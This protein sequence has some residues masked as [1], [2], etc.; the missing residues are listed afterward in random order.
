MS[1]RN[2]T[3]TTWFDHFPNEIL[4]LIFRYLSSN[5]IVYTFSCFNQRFNN[6]LFQNPCYLKLNLR[7]TN[8][9]KWE[10]VL[11]IIGSQIQSRDIDT[12]YLSSSLTYFSNLK[13]LIISPSYGLSN[14]EMKLILKSDQFKHL[15]SFK[16]KQSQFF[17]KESHNNY[18][19]N[20]DYIFNKVFSTENSLKTFQ[21]S[22]KIPSFTD[23]NKKK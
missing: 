1:L 12:F 21:Y 8:L 5:D 4:F 3:S 7:T 16:L 14:K 13:S 11:P 9:D 17:P 15:H 2:I 23:I 20:E 10:K 6:L 22:L 19:T 18:L